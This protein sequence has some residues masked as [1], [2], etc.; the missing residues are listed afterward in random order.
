MDILNSEPFCVSLVMNMLKTTLKIV[1]ITVIILND[2]KLCWITR[3]QTVSTS[4]K[5]VFDHG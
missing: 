3:S 4:H 5:N 2:H 1:P